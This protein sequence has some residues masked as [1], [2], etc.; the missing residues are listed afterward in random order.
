MSAA[1]AGR[2]AGAAAGAASG[3]ARELGDG[4]LGRLTARVYWYL[5]V[6]VLVALGTVPT[7]VALMLLDRSSGNALIVPLCLLP[8]APGLVAGLFALDARTTEAT[9]GAPPAPAAA[10]ARG[11]RLGWRDALL[12]AAPALVVLGMVATSV[13]HREAAGVSA[14]YA[15]VLLV[16]GAA[17]LVWALAALTVVALFRLR[18]RDVARV[19]L[20]GLA[21]RPAVAA[22]LLALVVVAAGAVWL[23]GEAV[24][25]LLLVVWLAF[26]LR[27]ARPLLRDVARRFT[28]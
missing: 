18:T 8:A 4:P 13:V 10:F 2:G 14:G 24:A 1:S 23:V 27:T 21:R 9:A 12:L 5:V 17:V 11:L 7:L 25:A 20:D 16:V 3:R 6:G 19:A 28:A 26:L 15:V 22:G